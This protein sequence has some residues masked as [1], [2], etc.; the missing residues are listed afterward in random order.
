M[1]QFFKKYK[2]ERWGRNNY[3]W[4]V[5]TVLVG[6]FSNL[7][8]VDG[9]YVGNDEVGQRGSSERIINSVKNIDIEE[10]SITIANQYHPPLKYIMPIPGLLVSESEFAHRFM[11]IFASLLLIVAVYVFSKRFFGDSVAN[12]SSLL[13]ASSSTF[14]YF[15]MVFG[16]SYVCIML[17]A[18]LSILESQ[19]FDLNDSSGKEVFKY[20]SL[21]SLGIFLINQNGIVFA[22]SVALVFLFHN[23]PALVIK[24]SAPYLTL[25]AI[26]YS[27]VFVLIP[28]VAYEFYGYDRNFGQLWQYEARYTSAGLNIESFIENLKGINAYF[29]PLFSWAIS[30]LAIREMLLRHKNSLLFFAPFVLVWSFY[31]QGHSAQY[32]LMFFIVT[33]PYA[34]FYIYNKVKNP[35]VFYVLGFSLSLLVISWNYVFFIKKY[36]DNQIHDLKELEQK[37]FSFVSRRHN[38]FYPYD[39]ISDFLNERSSQKFIHDMSLSFS[40]YY[41]NDKDYSNQHHSNYLGMLGSDKFLLTYDDKGKCYRV[42]F[43][44]EGVILITE[45]ELCEDGIAK[46]KDFDGSNIKVYVEKN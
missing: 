28:H 30:F 1:A 19:K 8:L 27:I 6:V 41:H 16:W 22:G 12:I 3:L 38:I 11:T 32:Y 44:A 29:L 24:E 33:L 4:I 18:I 43:S 36:T 2:P 9:Q 37:W 20:L 42:G 25:Y 45:K 46:V 5:F 7:P 17:M 31:M 10:L 26:Y 35:K 13:L 15:S 14:N 34:V 40:R 21:L 39:E 23:K